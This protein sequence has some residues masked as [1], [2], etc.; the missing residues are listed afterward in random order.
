MDLQGYMGRFKIGK[1]QTKEQVL[2]DEIWNYY[3]KKI[4]FSALM[5]IIKSYGDQWVYECYNDLRQQG[6][7]ALPLFLWKI[8]QAKVQWQKQGV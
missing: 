6:N 2:A 5:S 3:G 8:K 4:K 7:Y 1:G